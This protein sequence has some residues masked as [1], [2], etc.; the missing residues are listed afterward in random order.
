MLRFSISSFNRYFLLVF[1]IFCLQVN[2]QNADSGLEKG[3]KVRPMTVGASITALPTSS[4]FDELLSGENISQKNAAINFEYPIEDCFT[5]T[6]KLTLGAPTDKTVIKE[7]V[8]IKSG[9]TIFAGNVQDAAGKKIGF[10]QQIDQSGNISWTK[11]LAFTDRHIVINNV[12]QLSNGNLILTG[13]YEYISSG[14]ENALLIQISQS[15]QL[16]WCKSLPI[17]G[18]EGIG[19]CTE[20]INGFGF[21]AHD[22]TQVLFGRMDLAG[23]LVWLKKIKPLD[24]GSIAGMVN[25]NNIAWYIAYNGMESSFPTGMLLS[26]NPANGNLN[27]TKKCGGVSTGQQFIFHDMAMSNLRPR[28]TGIFSSGSNPFQFF[29]ITFTIS[30]TVD[31]NQVFNIPSVSIDATARMAIDPGGQLVSFY[32]NK[33]D[34]NIYA[35][36]II[37]ESVNNTD[38]NWAKKYGVGGGHM[39]LNAQHTFDGGFIFATDV[40]QGSNSIAAVVKTDSA[41]KIKNCEGADFLVTSIMQ[42]LAPLSATITAT[43]V[44]NSPITENPVIADFAIIS[45]FACKS[46]ACPERALE[47]SCLKSYVRRFRSSA[48]CDLGSDLL[49]IQNEIIIAGRTR[50]NPYIASD[51]EGIVGRLD[52]RGKL[53]SRKK[54]RLGNS[55]GFNTIVQLSDGNLILIGSSSYKSDF[56]SNDTG[57]ITLTKYSPDF[58]LL[59]NRS[60]PIYGPYSAV[61]G[62]LEGADGILFLNY[63]EGPQFCER[64]RMLKLSAQGN[65]I[66]LK[67]YNIPN[68]CTMGYVGGFLQ[69]DT[70]I[71]LLNWGAGAPGNVYMKI[72][73]STGAP[74]FTKGL[75][76]ANISQLG[77]GQQ[78]FFLG[79]NIL[80]KGTVTLNNYSSRDI[81]LLMNKDGQVL[82][83]RSFSKNNY[84]LQ[85]RALVTQ[86]KEIVLSSSDYYGS[87]FARLDSNLNILFSKQAKVAR[88]QTI[89]IKEGT[90]GSI[91]GIGYFTY[92]DPYLLDL[93]CKKYSFDGLL[94]SCS[95]DTL[96]LE[97]DA[98]TFVVTPLN[99]T[100]TDFPLT[101]KSLPYTES[102]YSLQFAELICN[103]TSDCKTLT[104]NGP[105]GICDTLPQTIRALRTPGCNTPVSFTT[106]NSGITIVGSTDTSVT[107]KS[108]QQGA[109]KFV[110]SIFTGCVWIKDSIVVN[111]TPAGAVL[112]LGPDTS[113]CVN[114][115]LTLSAGNGYIS[116]LW[117]NGA[118][119]PSI[120]VNNPGIYSVKVINACGASMTDSI[121][122]SA[123]T[124]S[125]IDIGPDRIKCNNDTLLLSAPAGFMNYS[126]GPQYNL[127]PFTSSQVIVNP[128]MDTIYYVK[129][130]KT[131]GCFAF[132]TV[133]IKVYNSM[134]ISLGMDKSFC[135]GDSLVLDAGPGFMNYTWSSGAI[136]QKITAYSAGV[137]SVI[138]VNAMGCISIDTLAILNVFDN[139]V[140]QL[141]NDFSIC[142]GSLKTL[143]AG[144]FSS[145]L[146]SNGSTSRIINVSSPG[147]YSV[148]V[149][150]LN[151]CIGS[152][153]I[154]LQSLFPSPAKFLPADTS[155]C[156]YET[157]K[158]SVSGNYADYMWSTNEKG[159]SISVSSAGLYWLQVKDVNNCTGRDTV[160]VNPKQCMS[161]FYVPNAFTPNR[162]G[163]NDNFTPLLFGDIKSYNFRIYNRFGQVVFESGKAGEGWNGKFKFIDQDTGSYVWVCSYQFFGKE[164]KVERGVMTLIR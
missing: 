55:S 131:P 25:D 37:P 33:S 155:I 88:N 118:T 2:G 150:D 71:Y 80:V 124:A 148:K 91:Y 5:Y 6:F 18:F 14:I 58:Q 87:Y 69:D 39:F 8:T 92:P 136:S 67:K 45:S 119:S 53:I 21:A 123:A 27:W 164:L 56:S 61:Y 125:T 62:L 115:S 143:D 9:E 32:P 50:S 120:V 38:F 81:L 54:V 127:V 113:I 142:S 146:W 78:M 98:Q 95:N 57:Y 112:S 85:F 51:E 147:I 134:P 42:S 76:I 75:Y 15:G 107:F 114:N 34:P 135:K 145:Y 23:N 162:D 19:I 94:G 128:S 36:R 163:I 160:I 46:L 35:V 158:L 77:L 102:S 74:L 149:I 133:K 79:D 41:G 96:I 3:I 17:A 40:S 154:V 116:Y 44:S 93:S 153:S 24:S 157:I 73:K 97:S 144:A 86:N 43:A 90:N 108:Y 161:G 106:A 138:A 26:I 64:I 16:I 117:N 140:V 68:T 63:I 83:T 103:Q 1:S 13:S 20:N 129:A 111:S 82:R 12:R 28:I 126:W 132:D 121:L 100:G 105:S 139:P 109:I 130:E 70:Y 49:P 104:L 47:D 66:W 22:N 31:G 29:N 151:N 65:F 59:W 72:S 11:S 137:Y 156:E 99:A 84:S 122:V 89:S 48:L 141:G 159:K 110:A 4:T 60:F 52:E 7:T 152:D 101:L 10:I 30:G